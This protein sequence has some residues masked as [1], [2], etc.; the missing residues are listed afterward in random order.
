MAFE[1]VEDLAWKL[2]LSAFL[3]EQVVIDRSSGKIWSSTCISVEPPTLLLPFL[4]GLAD[5]LVMRDLYALIFF[6]LNDHP[7]PVSIG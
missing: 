4:N 7:Q 2:L 1:F 5:I 6:Q 3:K